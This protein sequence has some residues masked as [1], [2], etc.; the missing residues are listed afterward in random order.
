MF[1]KGNK[2]IP[3]QK[4]YMRRIRQLGISFNGSTGAEM[5]NYYFTLPSIF[6]EEGIEFMANAIQTPLLN[7]EE[8]KKERGVVLNEYQ[9]SASSPQFEF[10]NLQRFILYG[11]QQYQRSPIGTKQNI[12]SATREQL[13]KIKNEVFVPANSAI[14]VGGDIEPKKI[15]KLIKKYFADWKNP[16]GWKPVVRPALPPFPAKKEIVVTNE[17]VST[18]LIKFTFAGPKARQN[19]KDSFA[20]D[21]LISLLNQK[22][23]KFHKKFIESGKTVAAG[24]SYYTESH[25]GTNEIWAQVSAKK[26][27]NVKSLLLREPRKWA[28]KGYF[29]QKELENVRRKLL[30]DHKRDLAKPSQYLKKSLGF[31]WAV[32]GLEY[33]D[34]YLSNLR[35]TSLKE[36][37]EYVKK[38]FIGKSYI[39]AI[40]ISPK[41]ARR[42]GLRDNSKKLVK[43]YLKNYQ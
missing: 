14:I 5:V 17:Q 6:V 12:T 11:D 27:R 37:R 32:T 35:S 9:R 25:A 33:Y 26:L 30:I 38:Y 43:K 36:V 1:F 28:K 23:S 40:S 31:W 16:K 10:R 7:K 19:P 24:L 2:A 15:K 4:K 22:N 41:D 8:L 3:S 39:S 21:I 34:S 13:M 20:A 18:P 29:T 42:A